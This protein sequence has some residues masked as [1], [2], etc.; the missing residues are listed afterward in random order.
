LLEL[1]EAPEFSDGWT[2]LAGLEYWVV[3]RFFGMEEVWGLVGKPDREKELENVEGFE[4]TRLEGR[5]LTQFT[6]RYFWAI[7]ASRAF[8]ITRPKSKL[9]S[10][11][12]NITLDGFIRWF[13]SSP[14]WS[15][16]FSGRSL[17]GWDDSTRRQRQNRRKGHLLKTISASSH[18]FKPNTCWMTEGTTLKIARSTDLEKR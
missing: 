11:L 15:C 1:D 13:E 8:N 12:S 9:T 16:Q 17:L 2:V 3:N 7:E 4:V 14:S 6:H 18:S 5:W 10:R